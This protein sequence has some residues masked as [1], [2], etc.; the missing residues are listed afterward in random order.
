MQTWKYMMVAAFA[1]AGLGIATADTREYVNVT[2]DQQLICDETGAT[3]SQGGFC[4][5]AG[6]VAADGSGQATVSI[7]DDLISPTSGYFCQD[8]DADTFCDEGTDVLFCGS[9]TL[10]SGAGWDESGSIVVFIDGPVFGN[11]VLSVCGT[12]SAGTHGFGNHS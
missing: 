9:L 10:T 1:V 4:Y 11:P 12:L 6:H 7:I 2:G 3:I 8:L 5:P